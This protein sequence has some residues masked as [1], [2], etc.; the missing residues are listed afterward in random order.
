MGLL[1]SLAGLVNPENRT[2]KEVVC[3]A[4]N[5]FQKTESRRR[6]ASCVLYLLPVN[7][8]AQQQR[9]CLL[10]QETQEDTGSVPGLGDSLEEEMATH[11]SIFAWRIPRTEVPGATQS[12]GLQRVR[13]D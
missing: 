5:Q 6:Q 8:M 1:T 11:S 13:R 9:T 7:P 4:I 12:K 10:M 3:P 2:E